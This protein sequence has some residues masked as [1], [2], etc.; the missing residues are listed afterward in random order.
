MKKIVHLLVASSL[1]FAGSVSAA[2]P[3]TV[4]S[5]QG[6]FKIGIDALYFRATTPEMG[7]AVLRN[8]PS[9]PN[10]FSKNLSIDLDHVWGL[11]A[12]VGYLFPFTGNDITVGY[13]GIHSRDTDSAVPG[14]TGVSLIP[15]P[16]VPILV[17]QRPGIFQNNFTATFVNA[18]GSF[19]LN[20][21]DLEGGQRFT[22]PAFDL[23]MF[24]G[25]RY[26]TLDQGISSE[27]GGM[28]L[29]DGENPASFL[30]SERSKSNFNGIGPRV[31]A[32]G[33]Y[34]L[35]DG[36][37]ID[38]SFSTALLVGQSSANYRLNYIA[39][40]NDGG[41]VNT[42]QFAAKNSD[43]VR[44]VPNIDAK[45]GMDYTYLMDHR[46]NKSALVIEGGYQVTHYFNVLERPAILVPSIVLANTVTQIAQTQVFDVGFDGPYL[47]VKYYA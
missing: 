35:K 44:V 15:I 41:S 30:I 2:M 18:N 16:G 37:G 1:A 17:A 39:T 27:S 46:G 24:T 38:G 8:M 33:R 29:A 31:G 32:D 43:R 4:P 20:V 7:Y 25:L 14:N 23:R 5:Q 12:Q 34:A 19:D 28:F 11:Y 42:S 21:F 9:N 13:T 45:V 6:G 40:A 10:Q 36:F 26:V 3:V 22:R 47:G